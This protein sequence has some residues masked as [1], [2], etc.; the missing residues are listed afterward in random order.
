MNIN[1]Q[2]LLIYTDVAIILQPWGGSCP[3]KLVFHSVKN[4][5]TSFFLCWM[6]EEQPNCSE[7]CNKL[8]W[9]WRTFSWSLNSQK[10]VFLP[11]V[12][13]AGTTAKRSSQNCFSSS[14]SYSSMKVCSQPSSSLLVQADVTTPRLVQSLEVEMDHLNFSKHH[15]DV[16]KEAKLR[17]TN[18]KNP[19]NEH[20]NRTIMKPRTCWPNM[21]QKMHDNILTGLP[22]ARLLHHFSFPPRRSQ[23]FGSVSL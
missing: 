6:K 14:F 1:S 20:R 12:H 13:T 3:E 22:Q 15:G 2:V 17:T 5:Y 8:D 10:E 21:Q 19:W 4:I 7:E 18:Y 16:A 9:R 11:R 23:L